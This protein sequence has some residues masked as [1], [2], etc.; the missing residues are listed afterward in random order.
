MADNI[1]LNPMLAQAQNNEKAAARLARMRA[2]SLS[3]ERRSEI[4][5]KAAKARW[6]K[7]KRKTKK[8]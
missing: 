2:A 8:H 1:L 4:A 7:N 3:P 6:T 5:R